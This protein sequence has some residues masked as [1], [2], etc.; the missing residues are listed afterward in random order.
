VAVGL[1]VAAHLG[2]ILQTEGDGKRYPLV[3]ATLLLIVSLDDL[4]QDEVVSCKLMM[5]MTLN[6]F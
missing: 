3:A 6:A 4:R 5:K 2:H 1:A